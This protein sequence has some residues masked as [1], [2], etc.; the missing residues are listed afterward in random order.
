MDLRLKIRDYGV[1]N[2]DNPYGYLMGE[3]IETVP[4]LLTVAGEAESLPPLFLVQNQFDAV[5][6]FAEHAYPLLDV[7]N[8]KQG[9]YGLRVHPAIG[10]LGD[11]ETREADYFFSAIIDKNPPR[12]FSSK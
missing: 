11:F 5:N 4:D 6:R 2:R 8:R 12:I 3:S 1:D 9:W 7:Y 10:H